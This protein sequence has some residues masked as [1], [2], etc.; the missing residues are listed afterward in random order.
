MWFH[1]L[2]KRNSRNSLLRE[3]SN[4]NGWFYTI[5]FLLHA[6]RDGIKIYDMPVE[7]QEDYNSTLLKYGKQSKIIWFRYIG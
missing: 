3:R 6:E 1:V 4:D 2:K 7:W 5:E